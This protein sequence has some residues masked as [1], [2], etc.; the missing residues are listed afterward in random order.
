LI[1]E[2]YTGNNIETKDDRLVKIFKKSD[3]EVEKLNKYEVFL[4]SDDSKMKIYI[5]S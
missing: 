5:M 3:C 4:D 2:N 1:L